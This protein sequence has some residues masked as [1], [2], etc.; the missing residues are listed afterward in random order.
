MSEAIRI[1]AQVLERL[2]WTQI[3]DRYPDEWVVLVDT[4]W[5][6]DTDFEFVTAT[7]LGHFKSRKQASPCIKAAFQRYEEVG[8]YWTGPIRGDLSL[9]VHP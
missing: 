7:V 1:D 3:C 5:V 8:S 4:Q 9:F 2:T 6:N